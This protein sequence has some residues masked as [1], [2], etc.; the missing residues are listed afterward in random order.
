MINHELWPQQAQQQQ[1][2]HPRQ[3]G[4]GSKGMSSSSGGFGS[5]E[6]KIGFFNLPH[7]NQVNPIKLK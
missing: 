5:L 1:Q 3:A 2:Q 6:K 7:D 4:G